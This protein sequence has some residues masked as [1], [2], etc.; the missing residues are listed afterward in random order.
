MNNIIRREVIKFTTSDEYNLTKGKLRND[1]SFASILN[2]CEFDDAAYE[3]KYLTEEIT[4]V[5]P[6]EERIKV[7]LLFKNPHPDSVRSSLFLSEAHSKLF[8]DRFFEVDCNQKLLTLLDGKDWIE[9]V[10]SALMSGNYNCPFLYYFR[11]FYPFPSRQFAD[12][13]R[14]FGGAPMTYKEEI[15]DRSQKDLIAYIKQHDIRII[16]TFFKE[17]MALLDGKGFSKSED[18][19]KKAKDGIKISLLQSNDSLFWQKN[20]NFKQTINGNVTV[21]LN[22]N[23]RHK[24]D[25][26]T[27]NNN[28][29]WEKRYFTYNLELILR[30][31]LKIFGQATLHQSHLQGKDEFFC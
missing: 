24:N 12:L 4:P 6:I 1:S 22:M 25:I 7:L 20:S 30:D 21:Y 31:V 17:A 13:K 3:I 18:V 28:V 19:I 5:N 11:C 10:A 27:D 8:W 2:I 23:T 29:T 26:M 14:L 9:N 15:L 16:I